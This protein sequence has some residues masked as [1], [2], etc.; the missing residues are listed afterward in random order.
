LTKQ[1]NRLEKIPN[2]VDN[3]LLDDILALRVEVNRHIDTILKTIKHGLHIILDENNNIQL[4]R[5]I[6][7][8]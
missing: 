8:N 5:V 7:Y 4:I 3:T 2:L 1:L 6:Q